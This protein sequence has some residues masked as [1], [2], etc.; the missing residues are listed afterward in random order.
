MLRLA[1]NSKTRRK[2]AALKG[3]MQKR[4]SIQRSAGVYYFILCMMGLA[5]AT[6]LMTL[7]FS[8]S[9]TNGMT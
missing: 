4:E 6:I 5:T 3:T 9:N 8:A 1:A 2:D 7:L